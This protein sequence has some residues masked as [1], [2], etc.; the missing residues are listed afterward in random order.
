VNNKSPLVTS[1]ERSAS[2]YLKSGSGTWVRF[3]LVSGIVARA[4]AIRV[5]LVVCYRSFAASACACFKSGTSMSAGVARAIDLAQT[6]GA[7]GGDDLV[8]A[9]P[10]AGGQG[11]SNG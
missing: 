1:K 3:A 5:C 6:A 4:S 8:R 10:S 2:S 7:D 9:E 11:H